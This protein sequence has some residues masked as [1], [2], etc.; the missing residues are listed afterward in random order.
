[1]MKL[2]VATNFDDKLIEELKKYPVYGFM[3]NYKKIILEE[4]DHL[5][6]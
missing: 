2:S 1:M 5:I 3:V 6:H 4:G